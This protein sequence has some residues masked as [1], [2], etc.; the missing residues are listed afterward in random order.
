MHAYAFMQQTQFKIWCIPKNTCCCTSDKHNFFCVHCSTWG[1]TSSLIKFKDSTLLLVGSHWRPSWQQILQQKYLKTISFSYIN[2]AILTGFL[3]FIQRYK[4]DMLVKIP[5]PLPTWNCWFWA[6]QPLFL[7]EVKHFARVYQYIMYELSEN[8]PIYCM[9]YTISL[10]LSLPK[11]TTIMTGWCKTYYQLQLDIYF[12]EKF[13]PNVQKT[14][15]FEFPASF[16]TVLGGLGSRPWRNTTTEI[17]INFE[18]DFWLW[19]P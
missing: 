6:V 9:R 1:R 10:N 3:S 5:N 7:G 19:N 11:Y 18:T 13:E 15:W 2:I 16:H 8:M 17:A 14:G 4:H 12:T